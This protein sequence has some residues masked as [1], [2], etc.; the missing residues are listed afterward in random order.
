MPSLKLQHLHVIFPRATTA[1]LETFSTAWCTQWG[2]K[3]IGTGHRGKLNLLRP[4]TTHFFESNSCN[5]SCG[6]MTFLQFPDSSPWWK[7]EW[8]QQHSHSL[9]D[10]LFKSQMLQWNHT[11]T[12]SL[13]EGNKLNEKSPHA[14]SK[15]H[16]CSIRELLFSELAAVKLKLM[17]CPLYW[18][19]KE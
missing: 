5:V 19:P 13:S 6:L 1:V 3:L 8:K 9:G 2:P 7:F 10:K 15:A 4:V 11:T 16:T 12:W 14:L 17:G 18:L